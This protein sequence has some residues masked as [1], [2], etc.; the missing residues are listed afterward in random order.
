MFSE[1]NMTNKFVEYLVAHGYPRDSIFVEY[2]IDKWCH[3]DIAIV[4]PKQNILTE[5]FELKS[6][7][8][9]AGQI[10]FGIKQL[11]ACRSALKDDDIAAH[12]VFPKEQPPYFEIINI[13]KIGDVAEAVHGN[14]DDYIELNY[15]DQRGKRI[16]RCAERAKRKERGLVDRFKVISWVFGVVLL[17]AIV[18]S[19]VGL[20]Q[21]N[22]FDIILIGYSIGLILVPYAA[23]IK[24]CGIEFKR[25]ANDNESKE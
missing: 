4:D 25:F 5:I 18:C 23:V 13:D 24:F 17:I 10:K 22:K 3:A 2:R 11:K 15:D 9:D 6:R 7:K 21:I 14:N 20:F 19:K 12:L 8:K 16:S 1:T